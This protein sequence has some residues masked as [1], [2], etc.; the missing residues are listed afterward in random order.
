MLT[1]PPPYTRTS[2]SATQAGFSES[3]TSIV[4]RD[5]ICMP[6]G[7]SVT[8]TISIAAAP[9]RADGERRREAN[10]VEPVVDAHHGVGDLHQLLADRR[11]QRQREEAVRDRAAERRLLGPLDVDVD[12]L[13]VVGRVGELVDARLGHLLPVGVAD[14]RARAL[15]QLPRC[16]SPGPACLRWSSAAPEDRRF[17]G[18]HAINAGQTVR[19]IRCG[20]GIDATRGTDT[21]LMM[22]PA[23]AAWHARTDRGDH[24]SCSMSAVLLARVHAFGGADAVAAA[25]AAGRQRADA[26][27]TSPTSPT[28]SPT[29]R[30]SRCG[31]PARSSPTIP[32]SPARSARTPRGG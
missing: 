20:Y 26:R 15:A 12:E 24:F 14:V 10:A 13:V 32:S 29:T 1:Q 31:R 4:T 30:P 18:P 6:P 16:R 28:G 11:H 2:E 22:R 21:Y 17:R 3:L 9:V 5:L 27:S 23:R 7:I 25:A 19:P 8:S